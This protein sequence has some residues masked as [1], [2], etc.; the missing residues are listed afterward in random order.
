MRRLV[1]LLGALVVVQAQLIANNSSDTA[2]TESSS[3]PCVCPNGVPG[4]GCTFLGQFRCKACNEGYNLDGQCW[5][6]VIKQYTIE[7]KQC[8]PGYILVND[9]CRCPVGHVSRFNPVTWVEKCIKIRKEVV[10]ED[11]KKG[12]K[13]QKS[14]KG[15]GKGKNKKK[16]RK[17]RRR[18]PRKRVKNRDPNRPQCKDQK[19]WCRKFTNKYEYMSAEYVKGTILGCFE[20]HRKYYRGKHELKSWRKS[21]PGSC[22][23][24]RKKFFSEKNYEENVKILEN[25]GLFELFYDKHARSTYYQLPRPGLD[26]RFE[27][28]LMDR[29]EGSKNYFGNCLRRRKFN[30]P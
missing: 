30:F 24:V 7:V 5:P 11:K 4:T 22:Q 9:V 23:K 13:K 28:Y 15:K 6:A 17:K 19:S 25:F 14:R 27:A 20:T 8:K 21:C 1:A 10:V 16:R 3:Y 26:I 2:A 18:Q 12:K 29:D